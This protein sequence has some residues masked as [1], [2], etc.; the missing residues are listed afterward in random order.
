MLM[1]RVSRQSGTL[2]W[3]SHLPIPDSVQLCDDLDTLWYAIARSAVAPRVLHLG[4]RR[5]DPDVSTI[6]RDW[7]AD[8]ATHVGTDAFAGD[9]V[10]VVCDAHALSAHFDPNYSYANKSPFDFIVS[11]SVMEHLEEPWKVALEMS[12]V[13]RPGGW[14]FVQTNCTFPLHEAPDDYYRFS[15]SA[16]ASLFSP[17]RGWR[18]VRTG[19]YFPCRVTCDTVPIPHDAPAFLNSNCLA[20]RI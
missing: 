9:D 1:T 12:R 18:C 19:Y 11:R 13:V 14:A 17:A 10:D 15:T 2:D 6:P 3:P 4:S 16:L 8:D 5:S 7:F 20:L